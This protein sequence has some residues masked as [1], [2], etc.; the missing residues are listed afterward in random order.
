MRAGVRDDD[1]SEEADAAAVASQASP[2]PGISGRRVTATTPEPALGVAGNGHGNARASDA[3]RESAIDVLNEAFAE[4]RITIEE[5]GARVERAYSARTYTELAAV[6]AD[7]PDG[8]A[9]ARPAR[10]VG[11]PGTDLAAAAHRRTNPLAVAALVCGLIPGIPQ[12][13]AIILGFEALRQ[14]RRTGEHGTLLATAGL[15]LGTLGV[16]LTVLFVLL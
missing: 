8:P 2:D 16:V 9:G 7:L 5:H 6:S 11:E 10:A 4:G 15:T 1:M 12:L 13:A 14:I 3:D